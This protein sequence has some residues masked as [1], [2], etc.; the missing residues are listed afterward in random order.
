M[1]VLKRLF[2]LLEDSRCLGFVVC[3][4]A[5][6]VGVNDLYVGGMTFAHQGK[7]MSVANV[8]K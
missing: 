4:L 6:R 2:L 1:A 8:R 7:H 3:E 5:V